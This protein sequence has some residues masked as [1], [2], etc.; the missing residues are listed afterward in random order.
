M[1]IVMAGYML[2]TGAAFARRSFFS[3]E[4]LLAGAGVLAQHGRLSF[5]LHRQRRKLIANYPVSYIVVV[6]PLVLLQL[7]GFIFA[8]SIELAAAPHF[9]NRNCRTLSNRRYPTTVIT[10]T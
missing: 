7:R 8:I 1:I 3:Q 5:V 9:I 10:H 4:H 2:W 6:P